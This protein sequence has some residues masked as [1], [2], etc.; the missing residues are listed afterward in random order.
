MVNGLRSSLQDIW[1]A[2]PVVEQARFLRHLRPF[3]DAHAMPA[4]RGSR[5]LMA[6]PMEAVRFGRGSA[7][8]LERT[9]DGYKLD[10]LR[11]ARAPRDDDADP[12]D[13]SGVRPDLDQ[14]DPKA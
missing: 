1:Q 13:C 9:A 8:N 5:E 2:L 11:A 4:D 10:I 3:F 7:T 12:F 14:P 6:E